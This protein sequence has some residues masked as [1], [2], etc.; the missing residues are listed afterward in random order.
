MAYEKRNS[1]T[2][3]TQH[4]PVGRETRQRGTGRGCGKAKRGLAIKS[5]ESDTPLGPDGA[6]RRFGQCGT[7]GIRDSMA[8]ERNCRKRGHRV[9]AK[10]NV[11]SCCRLRRWDRLPTRTAISAVA[12]GATNRGRRSPATAA[13][14]RA[15]VAAAPTQGQYRHQEQHGHH[16]KS[17]G[18]SSVSRLIHDWFPAVVTKAARQQQRDNRPVDQP[19]LPA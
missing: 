13:L 2:R 15:A 17:G 10:R 11:A 19:V 18:E 14:L 5:T 16:A 4:G 3:I 7:A 8:R 6:D 1:R 12:Q 9:V